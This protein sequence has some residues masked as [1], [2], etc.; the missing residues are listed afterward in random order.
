MND[1]ITEALQRLDRM[2]RPVTD[3]EAS[4]LDGVLRRGC[5]TA[6]QRAVLVRMVETYLNDAAL[7]AEIQGQQRLWEPF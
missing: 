1:V 7:A 3:W 6:K 5:H 4:F 2:E